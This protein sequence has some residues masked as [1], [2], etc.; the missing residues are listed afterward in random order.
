MSLSIP[1]QFRKKES[2]ISSTKVNE[3]NAVIVS[4]INGLET[5]VTDGSAITDGTITT[6][7]I[8]DNSITNAKMADNAI[9]T[10]EIVNSA[11]TTSKILDG[12][13][14][15][16]KLADSSIATFMPFGDGYDGA[17][18]VTSGTVT[19]N[20]IK[21]YTDV[22]IDTGCTLTHDTDRALTMYV[23]G[24][25]TINGSINLNGKSTATQG[26]YCGAGGGGGGG[27]SAGDGYGGSPTAGAAGSYGIYS[28]P[29]SSGATT[30]AFP[31]DNM[32]G[33]NGG[34]GSIQ[35]YVSD[36][37]VFLCDK[38]VKGGTGGT[39]GDGSVGGVGGNGGGCLKIFAKNIVFGGSNSISANGS[40]G[41]NGTGP[42]GGHGGPGAGGGGGS[43]GSI[44]ICYKSLSGSPNI[45][46][47][48]GSGGS[49]GST[50]YAHSGSGGSGSSGF[51]LLYGLFQ[52]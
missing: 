28:T 21:R 7:K 25:L 51:Y 22:T 2:P 52:N 1:H 24:T 20:G 31:G 19:A 3:N 16:A 48:G 23:Q 8:A 50:G 35:N 26:G 13:I 44:L 42:F 41:S 49:P 12:A 18:H 29:G 40:N 30:S 46:V 9:G 17:L 10:I 37:C 45:S 39:G 14:T 15:V 33:S 34:N 4:Y 43:G 47:V 38:G 11:V 5:S 32:P 6:S 27:A 36:S